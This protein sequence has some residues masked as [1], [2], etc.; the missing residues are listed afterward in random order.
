[1]GENMDFSSLRARAAL[2]IAVITLLFA[3]I[4]GASLYA[5][6]LLKSELVAALEDRNLEAQAILA[7]T[8]VR[9]A[10]RQSANTFKT[11]LLRGT[12]DKLYK[13]AL[14]DFGKTD[15]AVREGLARLETLAPRIGLDLSADA[16]AF[17]KQHTEVTAKLNQ[18]LKLYDP[19]N[20]T[21][22]FLAD[23]AVAG[24]DVPLVASAAGLAE[25]VREHSMKRSQA[26]REV[27]SEHAAL[28]GSVIAAGMVV[29]MLGALAITLWMSNWILKGIGGEPA[30]AVAV[31]RRIASGDLSVPVP[32]LP[33][34]Q[35]SLMAS[36]GQM[37]AALHLAIS[38]VAQGGLHLAEAATGLSAA[39]ARITGATEQQ[40]DAAAAMAAAVEQMSVSID[41]VSAHSGDALRMSRRS[42]EL[43]DQ[44][45][46]MVQGTAAEM[47]AIADSAHDMATIMHT[48]D[49]HSGEISKI[50][51][52]I[53]GIAGQTNLLALNAAIEAARAGEQGRGFAVVADEVRKLAERTSA[54]TREIGSMVEAIQ[55]GTA[56]A[57]GHMDGW[58]TK[59]V[60]GVA[61]ARGAG[62]RMAEVRGSAG[63]V[64]NAVGEI[65]VALAE[66]SGASGQLAQNVERIARMSEE[67]AKAVEAIS[68]QAGQLDGLAQSMHAVILRFRLVPV[69]AY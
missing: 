42:G 16:Q 32:T 23:Q 31:A 1:M 68:N 62:E 24:V 13:A 21:T 35:A 54:S 6:H 5:N 26:A 25:R 60:E 38:Q 57:V 4:A 17:L 28:W 55:Q 11:V 12:D 50:V 43:S 18:G 51:H 59:V 33:G 64:A 2:L 47:N 27:A 67:N 45:N 53:S 9:A 7:A 39:T 46:A 36:L 69:D 63:Q 14:A 40:S 52:V 49:G 29:G 41:Q 34:D 8:S 61:R 19:I 44:G 3:A 22:A 30:A 15:A 20:V 65:N 56:R 58:S 66:Q 10:A 48:L 37:Q